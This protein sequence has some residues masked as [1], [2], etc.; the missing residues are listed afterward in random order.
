[1]LQIR[2]PS[3]GGSAA[4]KIA[5]VSVAASCAAA[6]TLAVIH[7][8]DALPPLPRPAAFTSHVTAPVTWSGPRNARPEGRHARPAASAAAKAKKGVGAWTFNGVSAALK[9]SGASWYY[10]WWSAHTGIRTPRGVKFVPM[11]WGA[12]QQ[13]ESY[14]RQIHARYHKPIWL[15]EFALANFSGQPRFPSQ[16]LQ[17]AFVRASVAMLD[18]L[19]YV[20]RYAWFALPVSAT[21]G[22]MGLFRSGPVPTRVGRAFEAVPAAGY[23]AGATIPYS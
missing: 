10:T 18:R 1:M 14:L 12:V 15:T 3:N 22:S 5:A 19:S 20:Q 7:T 23:R 17:A 13:L 9:S 4:A 11:I 2:L 16:R 6:G 21:D 8:R